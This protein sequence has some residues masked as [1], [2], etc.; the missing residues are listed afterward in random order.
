MP[1]ILVI[2]PH[3]EARAP[4]QRLKFEQYYASWRAEG[5]DVDVRSFW[6]ERTST[7]L[8]RQGHW[9]SKVIGVLAGYVRRI[10]DL[11][12]ARHA[13]LVYIFLEAA[14]LGP[15]VFAR[16]LRRWRVPYVYDIDDLVYLPHAS[17][18]NWFMQ[19]LRSRGKIEELIVHAAH[20]IVCT[21]SL[22]SFA[23]RHND[24]VTDISSTIDTDTYVPRPHRDRTSD[25]VIGWSGS[26][27]TAPY[28][29]LLD[30][31]LRELHE[32]D[33]IRVLTIGSPGFTLGDVPVDARPWRL[34][35]EVADLSEIDIGVYPLPDEEW[36][37][38]KSG[39][40]ALQYMALEI[41]TVA[42]RIGTNLDIIEEDVNGVLASTSEEWVDAIRRLVRDP[43]L[44]QRLG[45][46]AR[47]T[48]EERYSV[49]ATAPVYLGV[50]RSVLATRA[51][52]DRRG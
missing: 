10:R 41:P 18:A 13:D 23:R 8:Y 32:T 47:L 37:Y 2:C 20:V 3:P 46:A 44:R 49:R 29:H 9:L 38:G 12:A 51:A 6:S 31:V 39:L 4:G 27:S 33:D 24:R 43:A 25:V 15:P 28:L 52:S 35:T 11:G 19:R 21:S 36:V 45:R 17:S 26:H 30:D 42:Q 34:E 7:L 14:P 1:K 48:I 5:F 40:K 22:E 16:M 50:L